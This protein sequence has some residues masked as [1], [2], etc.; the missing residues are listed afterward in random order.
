MYTG[1]VYIFKK[2]NNS[3]INEGSVL[4]LNNTIILSRN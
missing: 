3:D 2:I 4:S 1:K